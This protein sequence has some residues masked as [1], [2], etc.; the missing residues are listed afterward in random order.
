PIR[1]SCRRFGRRHAR[2]QRTPQRWGIRAKPIAPDY[3]A[4]T[5]L[6]HNRFGQ[7]RRRVFLHP[8][9]F[10]Q[11]RRHLDDV[12]MPL[13]SLNL[14]GSL[15]VDSVCHLRDRPRLAIQ[16]TFGE[17]FSNAPHFADALRIVLA[18]RLREP[19]SQLISKFVFARQPAS[20]CLT[21][22]PSMPSVLPPPRAPPKNTSKM[23]HSSKANCAGLPPAHHSIP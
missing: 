12:A 14:G 20:A 7:L 23:G 15:S 2:H 10:T 4:P 6:L 8:C 1:Q 22:S 5:R 13:L 16:R 18:N 21:H 11:L 3:R 17:L 9:L 19:N